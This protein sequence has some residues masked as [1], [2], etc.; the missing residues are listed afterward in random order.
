[1]IGET[2]KNNR[3]IQQKKKQ[4][5]ERESHLDSNLVRC[6]QEIG[7]NY[8]IRKIVLFGSRA[9]GDHKSTSDIDLAVFPL[10]EFKG[11]GRFCAE[12][13]DL[14]SLLKIDIVFVNENTDKTL[15]NSIRKEGVIIYEQTEKQN[16]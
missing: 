12:I 5:I 7:Q 15:L 4:N 1:M 8:L 6:I 13:D 11:K 3:L 9:R 2:R 14:K 10:P 16:N